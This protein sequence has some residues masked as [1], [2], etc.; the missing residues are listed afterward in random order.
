MLIAPLDANTLAKISSGICDNLLCCVVRAWDVGRKSLIVAPA[1]NTFMWQHP[2]TSE[3]LKR[4]ES[5]GYIVIQPIEKTLICGDVGLGAMA[6]ID[7]IIKV[8]SDCLRSLN[9]I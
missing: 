4:I 7:H 9:M 2:I 3:H 6:S 5:F 8:T 1:M